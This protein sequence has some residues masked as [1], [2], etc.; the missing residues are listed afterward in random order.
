MSI[1]RLTKSLCSCLLFICLYGLGFGV[2]AEG[3]DY[4]SNTSN[5]GGS[6]EDTILI[7]DE[8]DMKISYSRA[9]KSA[10]KNLIGF[11]IDKFFSG[12]KNKRSAVIRHLDDLSERSHYYLRLDQEKV[13]FKFTLNL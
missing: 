12:G 4:H 7:E 9:I 3:F 5:W 13:T 1:R 6:D 11:D 8:I 2:H 10:C